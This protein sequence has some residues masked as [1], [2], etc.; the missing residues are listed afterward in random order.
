MILNLIHNPGQ[1]VAYLTALLLAITVHE[2][3][4]AWVANHLGDSTA[5]NAGRVSLNPFD[6]L[7]LMG[8]IFLLIAGFGWGKPVPIDSNNFKNPKFDELLVS[9][10]GP[11]SNLILAIILGLIIRF[12]PISQT[13]L[14]F[15][16]IIII[17]N[18]T[19]M[20]FNLLPIPPLDGSH[21]LK[22]FLPE[23][24]Y[25]MVE[26]FGLYLLIILLVFSSNFPIFQNIISFTVNLF[27]SLMI[28]K[29][30]QMI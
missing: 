10:A 11:L 5:K 16:V 18:L 22:L 4:H 15:L 21:L 27:F 2:F 3:A 23:N 30:I 25:Y 19:L 14:D 12:V 1:F 17:I 8:T 13:L 20:V 24:I 7:D 29:P 6:H 26:Q 28:G 9:Y